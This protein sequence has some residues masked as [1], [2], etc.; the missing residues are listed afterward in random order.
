MIL[1]SDFD[2]LLRQTD[3][4]TIALQL[5]R[6]TDRQRDRQTLDQCITLAVMPLW[7]M[8]GPALCTTVV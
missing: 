8:D 3:R 5:D 6:Q 2:R 7:I 4:V 1:F